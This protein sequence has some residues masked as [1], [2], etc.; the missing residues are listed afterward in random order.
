M[1]ELDLKELLSVFLKNKFIVLLIVI[2]TTIL[3]NI[4]SFY[5]VTPKY[6]AS[7][8]L[9]LGRINNSTSKTTTTTTDQITQSEISINSNL[10][11]TYSELIKSRTLI[12]QVIDNL[13]LN[14]SETS[15]RNS[16]TVSRISDTEL[17]EITVKNEDGELASKI[18]NEIAKVF[19]TKVEEVYNISNVYIIDKAIA[20]NVPYNINHI[21]N[22]TMSNY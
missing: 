7:T 2:F 12:Q 4:Y 18:A 6:E 16:I 11:S 3:G 19:S 17:I 22:S 14:L 20:T 5:L 8:T 21:N 9:I 10:V 1:E 13:K 15:V